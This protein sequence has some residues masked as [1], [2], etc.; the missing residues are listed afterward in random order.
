MTKILL[1]I[2]ILLS[3]LALA[4]E[5]T[6]STDA[7][8]MVT[9]MKAI[10]DQYAVRIKTLEV[11]NNILREEMRKAGIKIPL[12]VYSGAILTTPSPTPIT[13][14]KTGVTLPSFV[15]PPVTPSVRTGALIESITI[16]HGSRYAGFI[17]KIHTDWTGVQSAYKLPATS[18]IGGYE[19]VKQGSD[20]H[21]FVDI[22]YD[23]KATTATGTYDAKI[24]YEYN[25]GTYQRKLVGFFEF[26]R[27]TGYYTTKSGTNTFSGVTR[28][29]VRDP[30][31][32]TVIFPTTAT[33]TPVSSGT[34]ST[35]V[36][37]AAI[38]TYADIEKA[39]SDKRYLS[40]ISLSNTYLTANTATYD[41]LRIRY[42]TYFI[43]GKYTE[44]LSEITKIESMGKLATVA[45]DAQVIATYSKNTTLIAKYTAACKK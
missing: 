39:Y 9:Q 24:L 37:S 25:T 18:Y 38:P 35:I 41:L 10:L 31:V 20:N 8:G 12:S 1:A 26:N 32:S 6:V 2:L 34:I 36:S 28:T 19:F 5:T 16:Q 45:C 44:S 13:L 42:R 22:I 14:T 7:D 15:T 40:V 30:Y 43:I 17:S 3:P 21:A 23:A 27:A 33:N 4:A 29:F 11:E